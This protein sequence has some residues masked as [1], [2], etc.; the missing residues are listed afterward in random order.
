[1]FI[2]LHGGFIHVFIYASCTDSEL[3]VAVSLKSPSP[4]G[5]SSQGWGSLSFSWS[6]LDRG[7]L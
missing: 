4:S 7:G 5:V 2:K 3:Q 1:M 6:L